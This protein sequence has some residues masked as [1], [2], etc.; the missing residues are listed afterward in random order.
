MPVFL[1]DM[2]APDGSLHA[3]SSP[4]PRDLDGSP[5]LRIDAPFECGATSMAAI[6]EF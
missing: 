5:S 4:N 1:L 2:T 3:R 6:E